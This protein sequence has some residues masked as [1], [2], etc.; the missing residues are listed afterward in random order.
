MQVISREEAKRLNAVEFD[1]KDVDSIA[2]ALGNASKVVVTVGP[3]ED[4]P[5]AKVAVED[6]IR[7]LEAAQFANAGHFVAV[8]VPGVG[9][10]ADGPL[11]AISGF[12]SNLFN[13][14]ASGLL[15]DGDLI[16]RIVDTNLN[17]TFIRAGST[18]G[19]DD[20]SLETSNLVVA[21]EGAS[22]AGGKVKLEILLASAN[23]SINW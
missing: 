4:G 16:D 2:K 10:A 3:G 9:V 15:D 19:V 11:A 17:F 1:Y 7:V 14:G 23:I 12:F 8:Y 20:Y 21:A 18:E 13:R 22:D 6:A 5:R